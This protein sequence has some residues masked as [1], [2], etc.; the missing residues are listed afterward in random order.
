MKALALLVA[1]IG[2]AVGQSAPRFD[3]PRSPVLTDE[4]VPIAMSGPRDMIVVNNPPPAVW[5]LTAEQNGVVVATYVNAAVNQI[6]G[7]LVELAAL[8][9]DDL[10]E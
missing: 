3:L 2:P 6:A 8:D 5:Q 10:Y 4:V 9:L 1:A 7:F